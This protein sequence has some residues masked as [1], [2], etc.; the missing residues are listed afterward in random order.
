MNVALDGGHDDL[1]VGAGGVG[2]ALL[3]LDV[4]DELG[5]GFLHDAGA[6]DDLGQEHAAGAEE[7][8]DDVHAVH[9]GT[10]DDV[11]GAVGRL[12]GFFDVG[13]RCGSLCR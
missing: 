12:A 1:A 13:L 3:G 5:D 2:V 8:S 9:E 6:L 7:V 4:W 11:E 10:F